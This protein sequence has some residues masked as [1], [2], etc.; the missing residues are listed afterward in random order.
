VRHQTPAGGLQSTATFSAP[1]VVAGKRGSSGILFDTYMYDGID[2]SVAVQCIFGSSISDRRWIAN[3]LGVHG[4]S[5]DVNMTSCGVIGLTAV[6]NACR[7]MALHHDW[8]KM[9]CGN[10]ITYGQSRSWVVE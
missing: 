2:A 4:V 10:R 8:R 3:R 7:M 1:D 9:L 6:G 5:L